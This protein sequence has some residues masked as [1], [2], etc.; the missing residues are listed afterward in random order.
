MRFLLFGTKS[1]GVH[2]I[3]HFPFFIRHLHFSS[4][5]SISHPAFPL[6]IPHP[7]F[8]FPIQHFHFPFSIFHFVQHL[9]LPSS[10]SISHPISSPSF[11]FVI[12]RLVFFFFCN[13]TAGGFFFFFEIQTPK[14]P[15]KKVFDDHRAACTI[16]NKNEKWIEFPFQE[17][18]CSVTIKM[19]LGN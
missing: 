11:P 3:Q 12:P 4:S 1:M 14:N 16:D 7:A 6:S 8:S 19:W 10:T 15:F 17:R 9:H 5:I 2:L 13:A 18:P